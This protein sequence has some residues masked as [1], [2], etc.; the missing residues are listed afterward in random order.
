MSRVF[1]ATEL[2]LDRQVV[3]KVLSPDLAQGINA[4]RFEREIR[5]A[6]SLQQANI[7]PL[8]VAGEVGGIPYFTMP[9]VEGESLRQR[10]AEGA[11]PISDVVAI[12]RDV[13]KALGY[14]HQ[15][16][17]VHRDIKPDNVLLSGGTAVVTDFGIAKAI[18]ASRTATDGATLTQL[19]TALGTPA[20]MAP[21]QV[22]GDPDLDHRVDFYALGCMAYELLTGQQPF[23]NRTPQKMLAAHLSEAAPTASLLR[24]DVPRALSDLVMR[25]ME[26]EPDRRPQ[27]AVEILQT[28]DQSVT[29]SAPTMAFTAPGMLRSALLRWAVATGVVLLCAKAA[30]IAIGLPDWVFPGAVVVMGLGLPALLATAWVQRVARNAATATPTLTPGGTMAPKLPSGTMATLAI[31]ASPHVTWKRTWRGG[32]WAVGGFVAL[33]AAFMVTRALGVGPWGSLMAAG[34]LGANDRVVLAD[35]T[36]PT[37]DSGLAPIVGEAVRAALSQS[38]SVQ[39][40]SQSEIADALQQMQRPRGTPLSDP[41]VV[42]EVATRTN[43]KAMLSGRLASLGQGYAVSLELVG[44]GNT[45]TLASFQATAGSSGELLSVVDGLTRKLRGKVGESLKRVQNS[46]PLER[47]TTSKLEALRAYSEAVMAND[48]QGDFTGAVKFAREAVASDSAFALAWRKLS[49]ALFNAK[50]SPAAVD[51]AIAKAAQYADR[52]PDR[53]KYLAIGAYYERMQSAMDRGKAMDAYRNAYAADSNSPTATNQLAIKYASRSQFDSAVR[54][55]RRQVA[56]QP[57]PANRAK[58]AGWLFQANRV[59]EGAALMDSIA[60]ERSEGASTY[61]VTRMQAWDYYLRG[62]TD[63]SLGVLEAS[64]RQPGLAQR[65]N[66]YRGQELVH[67]LHG[68]VGRALAADSASVHALEESSGIP[69]IEGLVDIEAEVTFRGRGEAAAKRLDALVAGREW[70]AVPPEARPYAD[71]VRMYAMAGRADRATTMLEELRQNDPTARAPDMQPTLADLQGWIALASG[72]FTDA[73]KQFRASASGTDGFP[74]DCQ[75]CV[76]FGLASTFDR[77]GQP[78]SAIPHF[79]RYLQIAPML[80]LLQDAAWLPH[81]HQRLGELYDAKHD[82]TRALAQYGAFVDL[83]KNADADLQPTVATVRKRMAALA[84]GEGR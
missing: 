30:N 8:L 22:A 23:A 27:S 68:E 61:Q 5:L 52:L 72:N 63:S 41:A 70:S 37:A 1:V 9:F 28:L 51:S 80:R 35:F 38:N 24:P 16:G 82:R 77:A 57:N 73:L 12:L 49:V 69:A 19:G 13:A 46:V 47:A 67:R 55:A 36:V 6:A 71:V 32:A 62:K 66:A 48:V 53:E 2:R 31:K 29:T 60:R 74:S 40:V 10:I 26:K 15:R 11:I 17:V 84:G 75:A 59:E 76:E 50:A 4:E 81:V 56:L 65:V 78:D 79:E 14:A 20:Y 43:A 39:L 42:R 3:V 25:L 45:G 34:K 33:V 83:W 58:L 7:V 44:T 21:E 54:Y 64:T 18:T